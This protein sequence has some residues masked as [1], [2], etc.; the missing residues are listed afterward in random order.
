MRWM[1][2]A[3]LIALSALALPASAQVHR[4]KDATG[5][6]IF[7]DRPCDAGQ[8]GE[9]IQRKR[10]QQ[11]IQQE[12]EQAYNAE[13]RKQQRNAA[14]QEREWSEQ[15]RRALPPQQAPVVRHSG[16][17]W[18]QRKALENAATSAGSISNSGGKW[19]TAAEM[20]REQ[21]RKEAARVRAAQQATTP[22]NITNCVP[23]FCYDNQGGVYH[24]AGPDFMTGP[25]GRAC[26]RAG[27]MWNCN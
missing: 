8:A 2:I 20:Q 7:S 12:R 24:R 16:N 14:E 22:V 6:L 19:D 4:C 10:S 9:Q 23:G 25:N 21:E 13:A 17:D 26:H 1:P 3:S 5:K 11:E 27:N 18:A 15:N